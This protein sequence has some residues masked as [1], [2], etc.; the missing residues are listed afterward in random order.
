MCINNFSDLSTTSQRSVCLASAETSSSACDLRMQ[1]PRM[2]PES[3]PYTTSNGPLD[4]EFT[5]YTTLVEGRKLL[6]HQ[7][8]GENV[9]GDDTGGRT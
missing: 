3:T 2:F 7:A 6:V 1:P 8:E 4:L 5:Q 9:A